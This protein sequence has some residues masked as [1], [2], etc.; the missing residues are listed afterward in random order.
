MRYAIIDNSTLTAVQRLLGHVEII[1]T[2]SIDADLAAFETLI[3]TILFY[4]TL[5]YIDDYKEAFKA[6][7]RAYFPY[8][9]P[10]SASDI[11]Y[12][13][14]ADA[15]AKSVDDIALRVNGG[16]IKSDDLGVFL[17]E[18]GMQTAFT[19]DMSSS[20]W[21]LNVKMLEGV[22]GLD[23]EKYSALNEMIFLELSANRDT[24]AP[25]P[26]GQY[27]EFVGSDGRPIPKIREEGNIKHA[28]SSQLAA[29][30]AGLN[31]LAMR[32]CFYSYLSNHYDAHSVLHPIR[33]AFQL[34]IGGKLG[35]SPSTYE[36][37][38][39][40]F[41][42]ETSSVVKEIKQVTD[43]DIGEMQLP[44]LSAWLVDKVGSPSKAVAAAFELRN[45]NPVRQA[46]QRLSDL[47]AAANMSDEARFVREANRLVAEVKKAGDV[48][49]ELY[50]VKPQKR[51]VNLPLN[52]G[53][54]CCR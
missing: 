51:R 12:Q 17:K 47:E 46:R 50:A 33:S 3:Q 48:L 28:V 29:F 44:L 45:E 32:T 36:P 40:R 19:W 24:N 16:Q 8:L 22:G 18:L 10:I 6:D 35:L 25:R 26:S 53:I 39:K 21:F 34:S 7:R 15:A 20:D 49:R 1:N 27:Y 11:P 42:D 41:S 14:F 52:S 31:W 43:P 37:I 38:L 5:F 4:D 13:I 2:V 54:Q 23:L 9:T 30:A